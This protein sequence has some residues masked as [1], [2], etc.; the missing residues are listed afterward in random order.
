MT[1]S[2]VTRRTTA[3][4]LAVWLI[5]FLWTFSTT[6]PACHEPPT[7]GG[8]AQTA[9]GSDQD[10][11][12]EDLSE[13][14]AAREA[15]LISNARQLTY[16]GRRA[17]EGY[18]SADSK[19]MTFQSE[20]EAGNPFYQIYVMDLE[21]GDVQRISPG[22]G[23]TTCSWIHPDGKRVLY[24]ST[25]D[26]PAARAKQ[27]EE[28]EFRASGQQRRYAWDYDEHFE[29][30]ATTMATKPGQNADPSTTVRLT[31][32]R[33]Y[34]AEGSYSPDGSLIA[35]ASNRHAYTDN[36]SEEDAKIF[37]IDKSYML[38]IYIMNSDGSNVRRLTNVKG[39]DGGPFFSADGKRICWRRFSENGTTAEIFT[40]NIDGT[41]ERQLTRLG[42]MSWA[43]YF[44]PS[45]EYLIFTTNRHGFANFELYLVDPMG[46]GEPVRVTTTAGFDGL[47]V[48]SPDGN[49]ISWTSTRENGK[50][51]QIFFADWNHDEA[52]KL[53]RE[54][55]E[56]EETESDLASE[57]EAMAIE[58]SDAIDLEDL[59]RHVER[60]ASEAMGGRQTGSR[61]EKLATEYVAAYFER[62]GLEPAGDDGSY[63]Q[64][65][66]FMAG[67]AAGD[68]NRLA[69]RVG[70]RTLS[71]E[72]DVDWR[73]LAFSHTG[74]V[75]STDVVFGGYGIIAP[76]ADGFAAYD[77]YAGADIAG[78]WV[79]MFRYM[80]ESIPEDRRRSLAR[81]AQ[82]RYKAMS[83]RD[84]G[85]LGVIVVTGDG[86]EGEPTLDL[87]R[88]DA[89]ASLAGSSIPAISISDRFAETLLTPTGKSLAEFKRA[90]DEEMNV[91]AFDLSGV[92]IEAILDLDQEVRTGRNVLARLRAGGDGAR[93]GALVIG[94]HV[95]HLGRGAGGNSLAREGEKGQI[96]YGADDNASGVASVLEIAEYLVSLHREDRLSLERDLVFA[97]WSG[98]EMGLLGSKHFVTTL[99]QA[100]GNPDHL[101]SAIAA[102]LNLDMIGRFDEKL[103]VNGVGSSK[104]WPREIE[105]RNAP[106]G[107]PLVISDD[108]YLPTDATSFYLQGVPVLSFFTGA[109]GDYHT[110]RDTP[111]R[112]NYPEMVRIT[113]FVAM[114]ARGVAL[115]PI[116]PDYVEVVAPAPAATRGNAP[117]SLGTI[118]SYIEGDVPGV[119]L[120]G[121]RKGAAAHKAGVRAD[122]IIVELAGK[123]IENIYDYSHALDSMKVGEVTT[124]V[125]MRGRERLTF[126]ITPGARE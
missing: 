68:D 115:S 32:A 48:F 36:L 94:A 78:K 25:H 10:S 65:F 40:M 51:G 62:F 61:G 24:A 59:Q 31:N 106:V 119:K 76:E 74:T 121:V 83:A 118:P 112:L 75:A 42:A 72:L 15:T 98:E 35:F 4:V 87:V 39:Y 103:I 67:V 47:P 108:P 30:Y 53:I 101:R 63:F 92:K 38:D 113:R 20:R 34:D 16:E 73:P 82:L 46:E 104:V 107:L 96:H 125:V 124:I 81:Y 102:N 64:E 70:I 88:L 44:H 33:G 50:N 93:R 12:E 29:L 26:D 80:P 43:P 69:A 120:E 91:P 18:F 17:G 3:S 1:L 116:P 57:V 126:E 105:R 122:D 23:K 123:K 85:A 114:V 27:R 54:A 55:R 41:D 45:G 117:V 100:L 79:L 99:R 95:D 58:T 14:M 86:I 5:L 66:E 89:E 2:T 110:P 111:D 56:A 37:E 8:K 9:A 77:S 22:H 28:L 90:L 21:M 109:H 19:L 13:A 49:Q 52:L 84:R 11:S 7:S 97:A 71:P 60:L 6:A